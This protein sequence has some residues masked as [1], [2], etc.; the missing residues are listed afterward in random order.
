MISGFPYH[1]VPDGSVA[2]P[3][4]FYLAAGVAL[5][6]LANDYGYTDLVCSGPLLQDVRFKGDEAVLTFNHVGE[7]LKSKDG[8]KNLGFFEIAGKDGQYVP[9]RARITGKDTVVVESADISTPTD[10][11]YMF[12]QGMPEVSLV[13]SAGIP[14]SPFMT[15]DGK[16]DRRGK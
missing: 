9:A 7:G 6:A 12:R 2:V 5:L 10:V 15:D 16:P 14:A 8:K 3:H 11:R 4:H 1:T 13:N